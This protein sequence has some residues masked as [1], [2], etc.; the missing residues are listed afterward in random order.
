MILKRVE[1]AEQKNN[2]SRPANSP[3]IGDGQAAGALAA[4][5]ES[6]DDAIICEDLAGN[7][8]AWNPAA[9][10]TFGY[11]ASEMIGKPILRIV[12][13]ELRAQEDQILD[14]LRKG[15]C[16]RHRKIVHVGKGGRCVD[17]SLSAAPIRDAAGAVTGASQIMHDI[18]GQK[19]AAEPLAESENARHQNA[20]LLRIFIEIAP[21]CLAMF[22]RNMRYIAASRRWQREY[23][24]NEPDLI[25]K[26]HYEEWPD[27]PQRWKDAHT[28]GLAGEVVTSDED[29]YV[30]RDGVTRWSQWEVYPWR[31]TDN[32]VGGIVVV[33]QNITSLKQAE[34]HFQR[35]AAEADQQ[36]RFYDTIL[37]NTPDMVCVFGL[38]HRFTYANAALLDLWGKTREQ[39]VGKT[40]LELDYP[41]WQAA[42]HDREIDQ[43]IATKRLIRGEVPF[44]GTHGRRYYDYIF[45]P[46]LGPDGNVEAIAGTAR[47]VTDRKLFEESLKHSEWRFRAL[48]TTT[49]DVIYSM[50]PDWS[51][52]RSL[53]GGG[54]LAEMDGPTRAWLDKYIPKQDQTHVMK[55]IREAVRR[56]SNFELEHR[57]IRADGTIGW[58]L[59]RA[60]P[61]L[62]SKGD[63]IEWSGAARDVTERKRAEDALRE[64]EAVLSTVAN[65]A[66]AGLAMVDKDR[67]YL[68]VN[69][70]YADIIGL[71]EVEIV[72]RRV[73]DV[74]GNLYDQVTPHLDRALAGK[75]TR[76]ELRVPRHGKTGEERY[77]EVVYQPRLTNPQAAYVIAVLS[78]ITHR[79]K[80]EQTLERLVAQRTASL[81]EMV[82]ELEAFSYTIAHDMRA[83]LRAM[84]NFSAIL[85]EE[86]ASQLDEEGRDLVKRISN[87]ANRL[88]RLIQDVLNYSKIVRADLHL[89]PVNMQELIEEIIRSYPHLQAAQIL[90]SPPFP[91]VLGNRAA[92]TQVLSNLLG[93]AVKFVAPGVR[94]EI[95]IRAEAIPDTGV[96]YW[97]E[98]NGIGIDPATVKRLFQMFQRGLPAGPY[99]GTGMGLAI[100]RK[101]VERMCGRVGVE[102]QPG[103]GSRFWF[104]LKAAPP[105]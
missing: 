86:H 11:S 53:R 19:R 42:M 9:E 36:R 54:F 30:G 15:G 97:F 29:Q 68:F 1:S 81:T 43:V 40:C 99:E 13:K 27:M 10:K 87:S 24:P 31:T 101:A 56:K 21:A 16:I 75:R 73:P 3:A 34:E 35:L 62:D 44:S 45:A 20:E 88:D 90:L 103:V 14:R 93:N 72:G 7:I 59:S 76:Y 37:S 69:Q 8:T 25:G 5:V 28:R 77:Y 50:S 102:S 22:D 71:P 104:E 23:C 95:H 96:R 89:E 94:P 79:K 58:T 18:T 41:P 91:P 63:V 83:P 60:T 98:D 2:K 48:V 66:Q 51:E 49:S 82:G 55:S 6:S 74:I 92:L 85:E 32:T 12:P 26:S 61:L 46:V 39:A 80:V 105:T 64:S 100:V 84:Q 65:E 33:T 47:D 78:D 70:T 38:D 57:V 17:V 52:M 4:I 67:S